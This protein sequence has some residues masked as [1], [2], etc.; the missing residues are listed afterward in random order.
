MALIKWQT[1]AKRHLNL[2]FD[3]YKKHASLNVAISMRDAIVSGVDRLE[4]FPTSG[5]RDYELSTDDTIYYYVIVEK[6]KRTYRVYYIFEN[7]VCH[8]QAVWDCSMNPKKRLSKIS[9]LSRKR[10]ES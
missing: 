4:T 2:I 7:D 8:I 9:P 5:V 3:Y 1:N 10:R 6:G